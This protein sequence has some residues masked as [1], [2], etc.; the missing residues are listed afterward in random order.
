MNILIIGGFG[1]IGSHVSR[2]LTK[3]PFTVTC[4]GNRRN[5]YNDLSA[6]TLNRYDTIILL[7]G[8]SSV[9]SCAGELRSPWNNN[10]RNFA[11]LIEKLDK[12][13]NV[14][15]ASSSSVYG[16]TKNVEGVETMNC[17]SY[18]NNYDLTKVVLDQVASNYINQGRNIVGLRF[19]TV[20]GP[21]QVTRRELLINSMTYSA[22]TT[23]TINIANRAI[24]RPFLDIRDLSRA[25]EAIVRTPK[26]GIYNLATGN[27][28]IE[29]YAA[30]VQQ[31][32][33]A[34]IVD[35]GT[36][37]G[38]YDFSI[39]SAKFTSTYNFEFTGTVE[40]IVERLIDTYQNNKSTLV[41]RLEYFEY[42]K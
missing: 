15:Y 4:I 31:K 27:R 42:T 30:A 3:Q 13:V 8:H 32:T 14:I 24:R 33:G 18:V 36:T 11:N 41:T 2:Y 16:D 26:A 25:V 17:T 22:V 20:N 19:G 5:D 21:A 9:Q 34:E 6:S 37:P 23:G 39:S 40:S 38:A 12:R 35:R 28:T 1:Y 29:Q 7:A 10:V